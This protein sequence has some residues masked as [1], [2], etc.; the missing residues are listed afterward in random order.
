MVR[1][2]RDFVLT[3][4]MRDTLRKD[5]AAHKY[6]HGHAMV[7]TGGLGRTGAARLAARGALRIGA[8]L[9]S[10]A[11]PPDAVPEV[12]CQITALMMRMVADTGDVRRV[13]ADHRINALC[14][15]P[16]FGVGPQQ[17]AVLA[18]VLAAQRPCVLDADALTLLAQEDAG[19]ARLHPACILTPHA[20]EFARLFP[21]LAQ[22]MPAVD[23]TEPAAR[24][25]RAQILC[26]AAE[27]AG[28]TV[29][30]KGTDSLVAADAICWIH[31]SPEDGAM[32]WLATAGS[33]DVL[34]GFV[35]GLLARGVAP[36]QA[37]N[38]AVHLHGLAA[39]R[40]GAG[41]IAE[42]LPEC[43]PAV[44]ADIGL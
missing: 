1:A 37:A 6:S 9:V 23:H 29:L 10:V 17:A 21:D 18:A 2:P 35:L 43:L 25:T 8:G 42:D 41:L 30:L 12:A 4:L 33:G 40:F 24:T 32:A 26:A 14:I 36:V 15:G 44:F 31:R 38:M 39:Q 34:A 5:A 13:L 11:V 3:A 27:R 22:R 28:C 16:G 19:L 20:G 7:F